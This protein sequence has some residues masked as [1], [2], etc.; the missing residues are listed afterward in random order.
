MCMPK[1]NCVIFY[2][3]QQGSTQKI[4][5]AIAE[6]LTSKENRCDLVR[7]T[8]LAK[9][10]ELVKRFN[11]NQYDLIG[12]GTPVYYFY[13]PH[14]LFEVF[15]AFPRL[16]HKRGFLFCTSGGNPGAALFKIKQIFNKKGLKIID[17]YDRW[18][19]LDQHRCY[20]HFDQSALPR[21]IG[22]PNEKE[23]V[24]ARE[25]GQNLILKALNPNTPEKTDFWGKDN[26]WAKQGWKGRAEPFME[27]WFPEFH[28]NKEKCTQCGQCAEQC[29]VEAIVLDPY[30]RWVKECDRCYLWCDLY[31][32]AQA[33]ECDWSK[34]TGFMEKVLEDAK[35]KGRI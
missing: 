23:L 15:E 9:D 20:S 29:P 19:G 11:F 16:K 22:H 1:L 30:P 13:P 25:F 33:V 5:T 3:S 18:I 6:G 26:D 14:H 31:C 12:I 4:A 17:G 24:E 2:F 7:F 28:L 10:L 35:K 32:P 21:S 27:K 8:K 34:Q